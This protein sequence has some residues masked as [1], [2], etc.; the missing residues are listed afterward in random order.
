MMRLQVGNM[1]TRTLERVSMTHAL[2]FLNLWGTSMKTDAGISIPDALQDGDR[3]RQVY[4]DMHALE[5]SI[6]LIPELT[7]TAPTPELGYSAE[8]LPRGLLNDGGCDY[9][10]DNITWSAAM[11][12]PG[13]SNELDF[14]TPLVDARR[15][16]ALGT[17]MDLLE[18][19]L[20]KGHRRRSFLGKKLRGVL[21]GRLLSRSGNED[22]VSGDMARESG[23][24]AEM[25]TSGN[26]FGWLVSRRDRDKGDGTVHTKAASTGRSWKKRLSRILEDVTVPSSSHS[27]GVSGFEQA[28]GFP[29]TGKVVDSCS[30][31]LPAQ[32]RPPSWGSFGN[33]LGSGRNLLE[34][35]CSGSSLLE[36]TTRVNEEGEHAPSRLFGT[37]NTG[38]RVKTIPSPRN[39]HAGASGEKSR[40]DSAKL[41]KPRRHSFGIELKSLRFGGRQR[42]AKEEAEVD[43]PGV[44]ERGNRGGWAARRSVAF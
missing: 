10:H 22:F 37:P 24:K 8:L 40:E 33:H 6:M 5:D 38:I 31:I 2:V 4:D 16:K 35:H 17:G 1:K 20:G 27:P 34:E 11:E 13:V 26:G 25:R 28:Q 42:G 23:K 39:C 19:P 29:R 43:K 15:S 14:V 32:E 44:R 21:A 41:G 36:T 18:D 12:A 9:Q 3:E 30:N 7:L